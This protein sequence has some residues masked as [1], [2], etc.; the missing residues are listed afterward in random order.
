MVLPPDQISMEERIQELSR[1]SDTGACGFED[2]FADGDGSRSFV[3]VTFCAARDD[4]AEARSHIP[5]GQS[6]RNS[7]A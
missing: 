6:R 3:I 7:G 1:L 5:V 4:S 2:L